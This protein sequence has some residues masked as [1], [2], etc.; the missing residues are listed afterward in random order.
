MGVA[1]LAAI[2]M[3]GSGIS[4][5]SSIYGGIASDKAATAEAKMQ[6][7]QGDILFNESR[8][9]ASNEAF[10]QRQAIGKQRL[11]FLANG[12]SLEGSPSAV[13]N[14]STAYG[15][16]Q[17]DAI[18]N[19]GSAER[20]LSYRSADIT[21]NKGRAALISGVLGGFGDIVSGVSSVGKSGVFDKKP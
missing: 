11:A 3:I 21:K 12:V 4:A 6:R 19:R 2:G 15:Q 14:E 18:L 16:Q 7:E 8:V 17:V 9:N 1:A 10:N 5:A 20:T 13:L